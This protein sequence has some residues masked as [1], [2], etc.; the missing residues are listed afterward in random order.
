MNLIGL[1]LLSLIAIIAFFG[2][3]KRFF[4]RLA[5][6]SW[7]VFLFI[8]L[9]TVGAIVPTIVL[10]EY[11]TMSFGGFIVPLLFAA[12]VFYTTHAKEKAFS[13]AL[14][15]LIIA[16]ATLAIWMMIQPT[17]IVFYIISAVAVG[18][19][20]GVAS[21]IITKHRTAII[22]A[23]L[24]GIVL[25]DIVYN[26]FTRFLLERPLALGGGVAFDAIILA[27]IIGLGLNE[28]V[29]FVKKRKSQKKHSLLTSRLDILNAEMAEDTAIKEQ[30]E[31]QD[32]EIFAP[33]E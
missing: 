26:L 14:S 5:I 17:T 18:V 21:Y 10:S 28:I 15:I 6:K 24:T 33:F 3:G 22:V 4:D 32:K 19:V 8:L 13:L 7:L 30:Q 2:F 23:T 1:I 9:F 20:A 31:K 29:E 25:G 16:G 12:I 27:I 11:V